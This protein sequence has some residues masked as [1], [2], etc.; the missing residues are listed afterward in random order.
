MNCHP[1]SRV[2]KKTLLFWY[3]NII[4]KKYLNRNYNKYDTNKIY[5]ISNK[6]I[7]TK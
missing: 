4:I 6:W 3:L 1:K 2:N 5:I 7:I